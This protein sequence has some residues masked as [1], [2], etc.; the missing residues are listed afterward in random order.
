MI[1]FISE[2]IVERGTGLSI[3]KIRESNLSHKITNY[4]W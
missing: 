1:I 2:E 4:K 3:N